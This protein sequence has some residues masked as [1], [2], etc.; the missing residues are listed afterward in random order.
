MD[1]L[2]LDLLAWARS[3]ERIHRWWPVNCRADTLRADDRSRWFRLERSHG[4]HG[5]V[6]VSLLDET[7][8]SV[9]SAPPFHHEALFYADDEAYLAG[10]V[11][12]IEAGLD[13]NEAVLVA[14]PA[15]RLDLLRTHLESAATDLLHLAPM[16]EI[17]RNPAWIIPA[18]ADFVEQHTE[19]GGTARGIGEPIWA[20]RSPAELVECARHEALLNVAFADAA[21]FRLMCPYETSALDGS[22]IDEAL[23]THP[24]ASGPGPSTPNKQFKPDVPAWL[25]AP[26]PPRPPSASIVSFDAD[27][28]GLV[29][30]RVADAAR[31]AELVHP[32]LDDA[33]VAVT[34][35]AS[36][37][38]RYG[39][40]SGRLALWTTDTEFLCEV[41]DQGHITDPLAGRVRPTVNG[42]GGR[43][44]WLMNQ[45]CD[46]VQIR[47]GAGGQVIRLHVRI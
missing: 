8:S 46:L 29:R 26:L 45:L 20:D 16:D 14:V 12:F 2:G 27:D 10:T 5:A 36:N 13:A 25:E 38:I 9:P 17:G 11:P 19:A 32:R 44:L 43:G 23:H 24:H 15:P 35:A 21:G 22:V 47:S 18:W 31:A 33:L 28:L 6:S 34:E 42:A 39:G 3:D 40:G 37:S 4:H 30:Q 41:C 1:A 7:E